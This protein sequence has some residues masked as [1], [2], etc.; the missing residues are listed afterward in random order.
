MNMTQINSYLTFNGNCLE[1]MQFYKECLGGKLLYQTIGD[2]PISE[3]IPKQIK[4]YIMHASLS[5]E[6]L[7]LMA[8]DIVDND[9]LIKGNTISLF[10]N[11][12]SEKEIREYYE[13]LSQGGK[14]NYQLEYNYWGVLFGTLIDKF[15]THWVLNYNKNRSESF[16]L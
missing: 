1:A 16:N 14:S 9:K 12:S 3:K 4:H 5:K 10:L 11:C 13:K 15:G 8:S 2:S 6:R 7:L